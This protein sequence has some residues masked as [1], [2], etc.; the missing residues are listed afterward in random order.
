[1]KKIFTLIGLV[2]SFAV[3]GATVSQ[4]VLTTQMTNMVPSSAKI[5]QVVVTSPAN[6]TATIR[7]LDTVTNVLVYTNSAYSTIGTY[8][9]NLITS[10]TNFF[11]A[12]NSI[13]NLVI[14][15][16]SNYV[17]AATVTYPTMLTLTVPTNSTVTLADQSL[18]FNNQVWCTN[19]GS[20]SATVTLNYLNR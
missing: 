15:D 5:T 13:T 9:T 14:L 7:L 4:V 1:M 19:S 2:S 18:F 10:Y 6:N 11:G 12:T 17:A 3:Y 20:G 8:A 16:Y